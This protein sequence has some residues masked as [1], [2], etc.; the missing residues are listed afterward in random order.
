MFRRGFKSSCET[1]S[2]QKRQ[3]FGLK[4]FEPLGPTQLASSLGVTLWKLEQV[5]GLNALTKKILIEHD[6]FA[7]SAVTVKHKSRILTILNTA[8]GAARQNSDLMHE[9]SHLILNHVPG[10][11]D[12]SKDGSFILYTYDRGQEE[13]ADWLSGCL[14]LPRVALLSILRRRLTAI[15]AANEYGVTVTMLQYRLNVTGAKK[16]YKV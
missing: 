1:L 13:E 14:L 8:H 4:P 9:V 15:A 6:P 7:W 11:V 12:I 2:L 10:R 16:Q 3:E 5:P